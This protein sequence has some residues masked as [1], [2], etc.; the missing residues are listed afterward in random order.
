MPRAS[1]ATS[2]ASRPTRGSSSQRLEKPDGR[3]DRRHSAGHRRDQAR[4]RSRSSRS[5]VGTAT[6]TNDY[7]RLLFAKIGTG[8]LP[9]CGREVRRDT[10][11]SAARTLAALPAGHAVHDRLRVRDRPERRARP[12]W[13]PELREEGFVRVIVGGRLVNLDEATCCQFAASQSGATT[14]RPLPRPCATSSSID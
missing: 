4:T 8:L 5:T 7:L 2:R 13:P 6:E 10:P 1:G 14:H 3:A 11:Q 12:T 9:R